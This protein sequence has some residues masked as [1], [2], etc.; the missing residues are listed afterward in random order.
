MGW[1]AE[2]PE[3]APG[4]YDFESLDERVALMRATGAVPVLTCAAPPTG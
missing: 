1:G 4:R 3:P 2:N